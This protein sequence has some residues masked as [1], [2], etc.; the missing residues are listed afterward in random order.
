MHGLEALDTDTSSIK[1]VDWAEG[2]VFCPVLN[3]VMRN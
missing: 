3:L 2:G 1:I